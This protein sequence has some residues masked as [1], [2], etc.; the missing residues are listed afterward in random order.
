MSTAPQP[1]GNRGD[2]QPAMQRRLAQLQSAMGTPPP[3]APAVPVP[4]HSAPATLAHDQVATNGHTTPKKKPGTTKHLLALSGLLALGLVA[5]FW[6][7]GEGKAPATA[8]V[9][10][11][12]APV[13][14]PA[15]ALTQSP[16]AQEPTSVAAPSDD[17]AIRDM[18]ERWR[19]DWSRRDVP[20]YLA[21]YSTQFEPAAGIDRGA[22]A[23]QRQ[24]AL[25]NRPAIRIEVQDLRIEHPSPQEARVRFLQTYLSGRYQEN[26]QPKTLR[27]LHENGNWRIAGEWQG[28]GPEKAQTKP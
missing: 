4:P 19:L 28:P 6:S 27:L 9:P 1:D 5:A 23:I 2:L 12:E 24:K 18:L 16:P 13:E 10:R 22:W 25:L 11:A 15:Q 21:H 7:R 20:A 17:E 26:A 14:T 8:S 3:D